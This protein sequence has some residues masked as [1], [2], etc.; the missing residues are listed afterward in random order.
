MK[1]RFS[2][3]RDYIVEKVFYNIA[4]QNYPRHRE[5]EVEIGMVAVAFLILSIHNTYLILS[6]GIL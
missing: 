4:T 1:F 5:R 2:V 3:Y 6:I